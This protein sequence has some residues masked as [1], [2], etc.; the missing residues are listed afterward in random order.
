[1][2][3]AEPAV[4]DNVVSILS[5]TERSAFDEIAIVSMWDNSACHSV[6]LE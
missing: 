1:M 2:G 5:S 4:L 3:G 6:V